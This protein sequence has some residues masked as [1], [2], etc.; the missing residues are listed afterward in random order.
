[1]K[2][3]LN[4]VRYG[5]VVFNRELESENF[6]IKEYFYARLISYLIYKVK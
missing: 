5:G 2:D 6:M 1:M 4:L 3:R